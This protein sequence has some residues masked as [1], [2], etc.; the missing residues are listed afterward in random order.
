MHELGF[1]MNFLSKAAELGASCVLFLESLETKH[2]VPNRVCFERQTGL[3]KGLKKRPDLKKKHTA[4]PQVCCR[5][6]LAL[7]AL[8]KHGNRCLICAVRRAKPGITAK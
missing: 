2:Y 1:E 7:Q 6:R 5:A 4:N 8:S 3:T